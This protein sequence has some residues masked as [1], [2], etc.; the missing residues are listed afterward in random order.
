MSIFFKNKKNSPTL[1]S[2]YDFEAEY[3][4]I[5]ESDIFNRHGSITMMQPVEY[6]KKIDKS[7]FLSSINIKD[8]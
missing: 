7:S 1:E 2:L 3:E 4:S 8:E 5:K 6:L